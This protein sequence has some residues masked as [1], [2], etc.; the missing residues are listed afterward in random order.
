M[1]RFSLSAII[2]LFT[3]PWLILSAN[4]TKLATISDYEQETI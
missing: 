4:R 3:G 2:H 1:G